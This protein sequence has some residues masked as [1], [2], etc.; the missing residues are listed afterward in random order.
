MTRS[1]PAG[2]F[3]Q[4]LIG[5]CLFGAGG[6]L[7]ANQVMV[8]SAL[9]G[10][11][12]G[13]GWRG[14]AMPWGTPGMGLLMLPLGIGVCLLFAGRVRLWANLLIWA[15]LAALFVGVLNSLRMTFMPT[16]L[17]Q[18]AAYVVMIAA[19]GGLMFRG[20]RAYDANGRDGVRG[21][22]PGGEDPEALRREIDDLRRR[23][24]RQEE[25]PGR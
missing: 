21:D 13:F 6:F 19:G 5:G 4:F 20:L 22:A 25:G 1:Q 11:G 2:D 18:L 7:M 24:D 14:F 12:G 10:G 3:L 23:L 17:W 9:V 8:R 15:T 16:T